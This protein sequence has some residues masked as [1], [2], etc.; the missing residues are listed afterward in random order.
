MKRH[1]RRGY[2]ALSV[3]TMV[4]LIVSAILKGFQ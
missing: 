2:G 4:V 3:A 1:I